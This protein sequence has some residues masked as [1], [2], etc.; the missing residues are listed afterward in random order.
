MVASLSKPQLQRQ[1]ATSFKTT[2]G[3]Y[4]RT[5]CM[6]AAWLLITSCGCY[7]WTGRLR[8]GTDSCRHS[9]LHVIK[10]ELRRQGYILLRP[11]ALLLESRSM[12]YLFFI[13][14]TLSTCKLH[15]NILTFSQS[16]PVRTFL[17]GCVHS[18]T[19]IHSAHL[20]L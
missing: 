14:A 2:I 6:E 17:D 13:H 20:R 11:K 3:A 16:W 19:T 10:N 4:F 5:C 12:R 8:S 9:S 18:R 15:N 1:L 7:H